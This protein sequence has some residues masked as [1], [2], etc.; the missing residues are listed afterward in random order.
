MPGSRAVVRYVEYLHTHYTVVFKSNS[1]KEREGGRTEGGR[2]DGGGREG[3]WT[4]GGTEL[5]G[6]APAKKQL[7]LPCKIN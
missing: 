2:K 4:E 6:S 7:V 3:G 1:S 5:T